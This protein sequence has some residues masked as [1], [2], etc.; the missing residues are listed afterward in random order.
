LSHNHS[1]ADTLHE[2]GFPRGVYPIE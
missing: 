2:G 1:Q